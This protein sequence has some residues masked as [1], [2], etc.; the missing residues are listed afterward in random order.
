MPFTKVNEFRAV[1]MYV[2]YRDLNEKHERAP[3]LSFINDTNVAK[4]HTA[5]Q[6]F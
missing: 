2:T 6:L 1:R 4:T 5:P 3:A